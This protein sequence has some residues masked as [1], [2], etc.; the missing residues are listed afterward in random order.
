MYVCAAGAE[1]EIVR[2]AEKLVS[3][4]KL[5]GFMAVTEVSELVRLHS[6]KT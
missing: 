4:L 6:V 1:S 5:S 3:A 2:T